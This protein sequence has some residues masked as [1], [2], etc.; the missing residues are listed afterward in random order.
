[1]N[2]CTLGV[3]KDYAHFLA[4]ESKLHALVKEKIITDVK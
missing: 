2:T 1:M 3:T 4:D